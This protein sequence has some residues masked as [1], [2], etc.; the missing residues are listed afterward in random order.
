MSPELIISIIIKAQKLPT[1]SILAYDE[2]NKEYFAV[3]TLVSQM[4]NKFSELLI[5]NKM[6]ILFFEEIWT[7]SKWQNKKVNKIEF[8]A[9]ELDTIHKYLN[10]TR[11]RENIAVNLNNCFQEYRSYLRD[12]KNFTTETNNQKNKFDIELNRLRESL[13]EIDDSLNKMY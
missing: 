4:N 8:I 11:E 9:S 10:L 12:S 1:G 3:N 13:I 2:N 6:F 7:G 5:G